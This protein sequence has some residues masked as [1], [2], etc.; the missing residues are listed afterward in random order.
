MPCFANLRPATFARKKFAAS[1]LGLHI[2]PALRR[3]LLAL[4]VAVLSAGAARAQ[5]PTVQM[6]QPD[7]TSLRLRFDNPTQHP[8]YL[9]VT[10]LNVGE[11][12]LS[13]THRETAYGTRLKFDRLSAGAYAVQL[14]VGRSHYRYTVQVAADAAGQRTIAVSETTTHRVESGLTTAQL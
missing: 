12:I 3:G 7:A 4:T 9:T 13:E 1:R 8:A 2:A 10:D 5:Q 6:S 11:A 14:R